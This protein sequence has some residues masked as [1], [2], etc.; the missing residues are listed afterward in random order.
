MAAAPG[1]KVYDANG[2][3]QASCKEIE[4]AACLAEFYAEGATVR[5]GHT[6]RDIV[7][8]YDEEPG[9]SWDRIAEVVYDRLG[10]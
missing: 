9:A 6:K 2:K 1:W 4:A 10:W 3:Y 5:R 7:W 8:V